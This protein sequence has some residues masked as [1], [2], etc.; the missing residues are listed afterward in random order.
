MKRALVAG[1]ASIAVAAAAACSSG[2]VSRDRSITS[3]RITTTTGS[4]P[5][6]SAE[7]S[8]RSSAASSIA[9]CVRESLTVRGGRQGGGATGVAHGDV[10]I[11]NLGAAPCTLIAPHSILFLTA[12]RQ[13]LA[14]RFTSATSTLPAVTIPPGEAASLGLSWTNWCHDRP[15]PLTISIVGASLGGTISGT[16]NGPPD[17]DFVPA[18]ITRTMP[19]AVQIVSLQLQN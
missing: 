1:L 4:L 8:G 16:F 5:R 10:E 13:P 12:N 3:G 9:T 2:S 14:I 19:S 6:A 7:A 11:R 15:G 18:C 17:F